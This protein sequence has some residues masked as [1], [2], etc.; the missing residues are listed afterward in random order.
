MRKTL[1][2]KRKAIKVVVSE[3]WRGLRVFNEK[4]TTIHKK[5]KNLNP[6]KSKEN[7]ER[8]ADLRWKIDNLQDEIAGLENEILELEIGCDEE[9]TKLEHDLIH[10]EVCSGKY[11]NLMPDNEL[12]R[13]IILA[14]LFTNN[15]KFQEYPNTGLSSVFVTDKQIIA[16]NGFIATFID[17]EYAEDRKNTFNSIK[18][19]SSNNRFIIYSSPLDKA[20]ATI[21]HFK[22]RFFEMREN[23]TRHS[24]N[25]KELMKND[26]LDIATPE[27]EEA[28]SIVLNSTKIYLNKVFF[29]T[30]MLLLNESDGIEVFYGTNIDAV[31]FKQKNIW[32]A[33]LP[34][35]WN[36]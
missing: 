9:K 28:L 15:F 13:Q 24:I 16:C 35:R 30:A 6:D 14:S 20:D 18:L 4:I 3:E 12:D 34:I 33:V 36:Q 32:T 29:S 5:L 17:I 27:D 2:G 23:V 22:G 26:I 25:S 1:K 31:V 19:D 8:I 7:E 11:N 10:L 21:T